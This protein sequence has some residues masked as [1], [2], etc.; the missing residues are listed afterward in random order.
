MH[1]VSE[2]VPLRYAFMINLETVG[3][4]WTCVFPI[5]IGNFHRAT[6]TWSPLTG[7]Q[8]LYWLTPLS[9]T[10]TNMPLYHHQFK[11]F[12]WNNMPP[13]SDNCHNNPKTWSDAHHVQS[14][15]CIPCKCIQWSSIGKL[16]SIQYSVQYNVN[17]NVH[18]ILCQ[19]GATGDP[20]NYYLQACMRITFD[21]IYWVVTL[22][23]GM[24]S[25]MDQGQVQDLVATY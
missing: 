2:F 1:T 15:R 16:I 7:T 20:L 14:V 23:F 21:Y 10:Q 9:H 13:C 8:I 4:N 22:K 11:Q 5:L 19:P 6:W 17:T 24:Y 25:F 3:F 18:A 12:C